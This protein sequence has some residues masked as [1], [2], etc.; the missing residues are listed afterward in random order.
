[1]PEYSSKVFPDWDNLYK[2][3]EVKTM[4]WYSERLDRDLEE[5]LD[6]RKIITGRIL[7]LGTGRQHKR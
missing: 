3:Q 1:M 7:D 2:N 6:R 4:P 5:E